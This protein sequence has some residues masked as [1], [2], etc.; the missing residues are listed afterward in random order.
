VALTDR[1][2]ATSGAIEKKTVLDQF[3]AAET[4]REAAAQI[5]AHPAIAAK[6]QANNDGASVLAMLQ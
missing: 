4:S 6:A 3:S 5:V 1:A 2:R